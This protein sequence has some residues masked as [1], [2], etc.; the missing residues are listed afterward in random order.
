MS[1]CFPGHVAIDSSKECSSACTLN[2][3]YNKVAFNEKLA[4][5][6]ETSAPNIPPLTYNYITLN[7]KLPITKQNLC[8]FFFIIGR[9]ECI[10]HLHRTD[11]FSK[12]YGC[13]GILI[14]FGILI[15]YSWLSLHITYLD[16]VQFASIIYFL[17]L[18]LMVLHLFYY[19]SIETYNFL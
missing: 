5:T 4:I 14:G 7:E 17:H 16:L 13:L 11:L 1:N 15:G 12:T 8:I 9:V 18:K 6:K 2:S 3:A 10:S 19:K